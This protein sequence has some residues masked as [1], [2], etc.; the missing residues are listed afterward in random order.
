MFNQ[1]IWFSFPAVDVVQ[2]S[3]WIALLKK[4]TPLQ[5]LM[6]NF[7]KPVHISAFLVQL[8][9]SLQVTAWLHL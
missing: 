2:L 8:S 5:N 7:V 1:C 6:C 3:D 9:F 4:S